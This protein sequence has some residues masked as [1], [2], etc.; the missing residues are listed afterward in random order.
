MKI[1]LN[2]FGTCLVVFKFQLKDPKIK[3]PDLNLNRYDPP[4]L[5]AVQRH[6]RKFEDSKKHSYGGIRKKDI[7]KKS[8]L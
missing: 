6:L 5:V 7:D 2:T 3:R 8:I 4:C 1:K